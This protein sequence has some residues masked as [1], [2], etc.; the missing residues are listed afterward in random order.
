MSDFSS[1]IYG[2]VVVP[3]EAV[4]ADQ[5]GGLKEGWAKTERFRQRVNASATAMDSNMLSCKAKG[6]PFHLLT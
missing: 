4:L 3:V 1:N 6:R 2:E 5:D